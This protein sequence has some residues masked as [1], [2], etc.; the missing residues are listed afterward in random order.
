MN[1]AVRNEI[2]K[3]AGRPCSARHIHGRTIVRLQAWRVPN[4]DGAV[5]AGRYGGTWR[6][7]RSPIYRCRSF[8]IDGRPVVR[9]MA[10][11]LA[12]QPHRYEWIDWSGG[13]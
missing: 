11:I 3:I 13:R 9:S 7:D 10:A 5:C 2:V 4:E 1:R 12:D 6:D 8:T